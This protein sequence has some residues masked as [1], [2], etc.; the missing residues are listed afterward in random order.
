MSKGCLDGFKCYPDLPDF[1]KDE[2]APFDSYNEAFQGKKTIYEHMRF[3]QSIWEEI[4]GENM[5]WNKNWNELYPDGEPATQFDTLPL[6]GCDGDYNIGRLN[7]KFL[8][9]FLAYYNY[10]RA[11]GGHPKCI[12]SDWKAL[13]VQA[14]VYATRGSGCRGHYPTEDECSLK[15]VCDEMY[16]YVSDATTSSNLMIGGNDGCA[17]DEAWPDHHANLQGIW[18]ESSSN[19][20]AGMGHRLAFS[21]THGTFAYGYAGSARYYFVGKSD[22]TRDEEDIPGYSDFF[23]ISDNDLST[24]GVFQ[25][26]YP[27]LATPYEILPN[28]KNEKGENRNWASHE[29]TLFKVDRRYFPTKEDFPNFNVLLEHFSGTSTT[30][31]K[32]LNDREYD[33]VRGADESSQYKSPYL[34]GGEPI[35]S[36]HK[37]QFDNYTGGDFISCLNEWQFKARQPFEWFATMN[38]ELSDPDHP[39]NVHMYKWTF[40]VSHTSPDE[41]SSDKAVYEQWFYSHRLFHLTPS[42]G[43]QFLP[44]F[45]LMAL[46][47]GGCVL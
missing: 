31:L 28:Y 42:S 29:Q 45:A 2:K 40:N 24:R 44:S 26:V 47:I 25:W 4:P 7:K 16:E 14:A 6:F 21:W 5:S 30:S 20:P 8:T 13:R 11:I 34:L 33:C 27:G 10:M 38:R 15:G 17:W 32:K 3:L 43:R 41:K 12:M 37:M 39:N 18:A 22:D 35:P 23:K 1:P 19:S 36:G 46:L 9:H